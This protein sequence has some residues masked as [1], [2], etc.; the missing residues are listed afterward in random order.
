MVLETKALLRD[1]R[2]IDLPFC[3]ALVRQAGL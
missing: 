2:E 1:D 3:R